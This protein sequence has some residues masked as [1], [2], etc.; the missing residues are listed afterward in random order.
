MTQSDQLSSNYIG[1]GGKIG[2]RILGLENNWTL[3]VYISCITVENVF[4]VPTKTTSQISCCK[5]TLFNEPTFFD[6]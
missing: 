2:K 4:T 1:N 5:V 6:F 3:D